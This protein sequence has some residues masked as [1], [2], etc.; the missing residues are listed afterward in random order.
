[1]DILLTTEQKKEWQR[2]VK[3]L[4]KMERPPTS[5][6]EYELWQRFHFGLSI[7]K[8]ESRALNSMQ[9]Y[10]RLE[11]LLLSPDQSNEL[12]AGVIRKEKICDKGFYAMAWP[13]A[14]DKVFKEIGYQ[15]FPGRTERLMELLLEGKD[16]NPEEWFRHNRADSLIIAQQWLKEGGYRQLPLVTVFPVSVEAY[17][18][19]FDANKNHLGVLKD[20][21]VRVFRFKDPE[22]LSREE[23]PYYY[24]ASRAQHYLCKEAQLP[25]PLEQY[26][27][28]AVKLKVS[29]LSE[30]KCLPILPRPACYDAK[31]DA[32]EPAKTRAAGKRAAIDE[33]YDE[34][35][36]AP[37]E[38]YPHTPLRYIGIGKISGKETVEQVL[39]L[40][41]QHNFVSRLPK[42][43]EGDPVNDLS[44]TVLKIP[45]KKKVKAWVAK[46]NPHARFAMSG[47]LTLSVR[48]LASAVPL[49]VA[50]TV[51]ESNEDSG[52]PCGIEV[53][54]E[55]CNLAL[56][57][58]PSQG[59]EITDDSTLAKNIQI[60][61]AEI[62]QT[63]GI[64]L[65]E[66]I[67]PEHVPEG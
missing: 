9:E 49:P 34:I 16:K 30:F 32:P 27:I 41:K 63:L 18:R 38:D 40:F 56:Y 46:F 22:S 1:M 36:P 28:Q 61:L 3:V 19:R 26:I 5:Q 51:F 58:E 14:M 20:L 2:L 67:P 10:H 57:I 33:F 65:H 21:Y 29:R 25:E 62:K 15:M 39:I 24:L 52:E 31:P 43:S 42:V 44:H 55:Q 54:E 17:V 4:R 6:L 53:K 12:F 60:I 13:I 66:S 64:E 48:I 11:E 35:Y 59:E 50:T 47:E 7:S 23:S 45:P 8:Q 37:D